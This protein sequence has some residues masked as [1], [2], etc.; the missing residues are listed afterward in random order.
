M[1]EKQTS[2]S[3]C[4]TGESALVGAMGR[5]STHRTHDQMMFAA[6]TLELFNQVTTDDVENP[7]QSPTHRSRT[8]VSA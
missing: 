2:D 8:F 4:V 6:M 3:E 7:R 5:R 1:I